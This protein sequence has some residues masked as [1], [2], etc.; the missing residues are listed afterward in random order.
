MEIVPV[1]GGM[2]VVVQKDQEQ[3]LMVPAVIRGITII[4]FPTFT[5][6]VEVQ[7]LEEMEY[8]ETGIVL[9]THRSLTN[10]YTTTKSSTQSAF[11]FGRSRTSIP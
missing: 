9:D 11:G 7:A 10:H 1:L 8:M 4:Q 3:L 5:H 6:R 2:E